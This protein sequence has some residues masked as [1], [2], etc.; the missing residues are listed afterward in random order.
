MTW[1]P[2]EHPDAENPVWQKY[3]PIAMRQAAT[4]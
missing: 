3:V 2:R 4:E 1:M